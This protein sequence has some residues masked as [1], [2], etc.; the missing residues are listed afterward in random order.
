MK[1]SI[2]ILPV[3]MLLPCAL[4]AQKRPPALSDKTLLKLFAAFKQ[5]EGYA[6]QVQTESY[7]TGE[8]DRVVM[9]Q[10]SVYLSIA[11]FVSYSSSEREVVL[12]CREGQFKADKQSKTVRYKIFAS[13]SEFQQVAGSYTTA[14]NQGLDSIFLKDAFVSSK[15]TGKTT[16]SYRL[17][18]GQSSYFKDLNLV[19][20]RTDSIPDSLVYIIERPVPG[21]NGTGKET[22]I[23]Q[24][25]KTSGYKK[26]VPGEVGRMQQQ[27]MIEFLQKDYK[28][29]KLQNI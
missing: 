19:C 28:G 23:I 18:Y 22:T 21:Y 7:A 8:P 15:T 3:L 29:Y 10:T 9:E 6:Y 24:K 1:G 16:I 17:S 13:D 12:L 2:L 26:Q 5:A 25:V 4:F 20:R 11:P 14:L 27:G